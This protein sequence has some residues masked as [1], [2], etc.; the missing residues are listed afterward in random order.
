MSF[1]ILSQHTA[2]FKF[3]GNNIAGL[4]Q[5]LLLQRTLISFHKLL[6]SFLLEKKLCLFHHAVE[7]IT[8]L[9][10]SLLAPFRENLVAGREQSVA[11]IWQ[12]IRFCI[13]QRNLSD[14]G[15]SDRSVLHSGSVANIR[16]GNRKMLPLEWELGC[17]LCGVLHYSDQSDFNTVLGLKISNLCSLLHDH[18]QWRVSFGLSGICSLPQGV[19]GRCHQLL[20]LFWAQT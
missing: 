15:Y 9:A 10:S 14:L 2:F 20:N 13:F 16:E 8:C 5:N 1:S 12:Y 4:G 18:M 17:F 19:W 3:K 6:L 11:G 7:L